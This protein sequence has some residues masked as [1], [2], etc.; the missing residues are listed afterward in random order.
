MRKSRSA[1]IIT[2]GILV[3]GA[4]V[5][6]HHSYAARFAHYTSLVVF[7]GFLSQPRLKTVYHAIVAFILNTIELPKTISSEV[8]VENENKKKMKKRWRWIKLLV[9]PWLVFWVFYLIFYFSNPVFSEYCDQFWNALGTFFESIFTEISF[10]W[11]LQSIAGMTI[12]ALIVYKSSSNSLTNYEAQLNTTILR[13]RRSTSTAFSFGKRTFISLKNEHR[14][15][16]LLI[17]SINLLLLVVNGIDIQWIW[18]N[19]EYDGNYN[20]SHLVH[21]GTYLLILSIL[22]SMGILLYFFRRNLNFFPNNTWLRRL[23]NAW[24]FQNVVLVISVVIRN[25]HYMYHYGLAYKRIGVMF[26][27][28]AVIIGLFTLYIKINHAKTSFYLL[29]INSWAVYGLLLL[30]SCIN[31]DM[32]IVKHNIKYTQEKNLDVEFLLSLSDKTLPILH[33]NRYK[34]NLI[35]TNY[36]GTTLDKRIEQF[37]K[38]NKDLSWKSWNYADAQAIEYFESNSGD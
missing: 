31:W 25:Y 30:M 33:Q 24:I 26:F 28:C 20:L 3:T 2:L 12:F 15:A 13:Q 17:V 1:K 27:L 29:K 14:S 6:L 5:V 35:D 23:A 4:M 8:V 9:I 16:L 34:L 38:D 11:M 32:V 19:F 18:F 36:K 37:K 7:V 21:E 10:P 22:L